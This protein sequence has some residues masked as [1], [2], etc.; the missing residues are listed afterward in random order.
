MD[1]CIYLFYILDYNLILLYFK[2]IV[3]TGVVGSSSV[4]SYVSDLLPSMCKIFFFSFLFE[5]FLT[6]WHY[7]V[8]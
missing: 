8:L 6:F 7:K 3:P 4:G 1:L 5:H 2:E